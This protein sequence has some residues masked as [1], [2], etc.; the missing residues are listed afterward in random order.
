MNVYILFGQGLGLGHCQVKVCNVFAAVPFSLCGGCGFLG[1]Y[2]I[3][4][5]AEA[6]GQESTPL[7]RESTEAPLLL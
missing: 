5:C 2:Q 1:I 7:S 4:C 6:G 3:L